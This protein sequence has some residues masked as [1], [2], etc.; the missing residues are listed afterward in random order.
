MGVK[1]GVV[2]IMIFDKKHGFDGFAIELKVGYNKPSN[3]QKEWLKKLSNLNWC[4]LCTWSLDEFIEKID[5]Y[6]S[7]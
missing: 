5:W 1:K 7:L 2:D 6:Y 3:E 4:T